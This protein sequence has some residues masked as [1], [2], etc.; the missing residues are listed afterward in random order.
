MAAILHLVKGRAD[1][2][3]HT[4]PGHNFPAGAERIAGYLQSLFP[5]A[6]VDQLNVARVHVD[7]RRDAGRGRPGHVG[8]KAIPVDS[9]VGSEGEKDCG[10]A[11]NLPAWADQRGRINR[12]CEYGMTEAHHARSVPDFVASIDF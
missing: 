10:H 9:P 5:R 7:R 11:A 8:R 3:D 4:R 6:V 1:R 12:L 2:I